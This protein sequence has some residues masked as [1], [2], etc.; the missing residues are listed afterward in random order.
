MKHRRLSECYTQSL[1]DADVFVFVF[2]DE[3]P[4]GQPEGE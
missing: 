1:F 2:I 3:M 4:N